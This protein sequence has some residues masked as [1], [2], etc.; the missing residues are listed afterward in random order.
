MG[1]FEL[2]TRRLLLRE[3]RASDR[4]P[5]AEMNGDPVVME[6]FPATLDPSAS[7]SLVDRFSDEFARCGFCPWAVEKLD[8]GTFIGFVGL[9]EVPRAMPFS[10]AVE[11]G[12]RLAQT[13]WGSGYATEA[14]TAALDFGF[15]VT[16]L[17]EIVSFTSVVNRRSQRVMER[18]G[19]SRDPREDFEH[20]G[21]P[22]RHLL[23]RHVLYRLRSSGSPPPTGFIQQRQVASDRAPR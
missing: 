21:V 9:H 16:G 13:F 3:W 20:P 17:D 15:N 18:L 10:P 19:M 7:D 4:A 2:R 23:R 12:W 11:V 22:E 1:G 8:D 5:F 14:G 6:F